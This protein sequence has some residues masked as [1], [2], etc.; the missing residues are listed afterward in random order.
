GAAPL[1]ADDALQTQLGHQPLDGTACHEDALA[2]QCAGDPADAIGAAG[3]GM[4]LFDQRL[5]LLVTQPTGRLRPLLA[6]VVRRLRQS[7]H[8]AGEPDPE[9][10][11]LEVLDHLVG[12]VRGRSSSAAKT[13]SRPSESRSPASAPLLLCGVASVPRA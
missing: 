4:D 5:K 6:R 8:P 2:P 13:R 11:V 9:A 1:A 7:Q 10:L 3:L 12:L